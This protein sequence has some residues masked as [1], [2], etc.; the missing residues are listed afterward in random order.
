MEEESVENKKPESKR[1]AVPA[2]FLVIALLIGGALGYGIGNR[3]AD[4][5]GPTMDETM[6]GMTSHL[7]HVTAG[8]E[9]DKAFLREMIVHHEGAVEMAELVLEKSDRPELRDLAQAIITAQRREISDMQK[10]LD[11]WF[12]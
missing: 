10:W 4:N 1:G 2:F 9:F 7:G 12:R 5:V 11:E 8:E 3:S 6:Q